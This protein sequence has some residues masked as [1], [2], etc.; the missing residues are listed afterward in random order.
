[1]RGMKA[2]TVRLNDIDMYYETE[3]EGVPSCSF[4]VA[5]DARR[6]GYMQARMF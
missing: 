2:E 1:M 6:I 3:G 4:T 5:L